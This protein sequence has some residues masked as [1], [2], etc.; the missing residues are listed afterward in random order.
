MDAGFVGKGVGTDN[1]LVGLD[2]H[3]RIA[4]DHVA[5]AV[6]LLRLHIGAQAVELRPGIESHDELLQRRV[7]R[8]FADAVNGHLHL[9]GSGRDGR[10]RVGSGQ[11][12][13][14]VCVRAEDYVPPA[15]RAFDQLP[16]QRLI[17]LRLRVA[18]GVGDVERGRAG[19]NC[20]LQHLLEVLDVATPGILRTE[21]DI[22]AQADRVLHHLAHRLQYLVARHAQLVLQMNV[23]GRNEGVDA[24]PHGRFGGG[25]RP[26]D[27]H[28]VGAGQPGDH[29][30]R[31]CA[32]V[33]ADTD[34][35]PD[36]LRHPVD[37]LPVAGAGNG[38]ARLED[39]DAQ[40]GQLASQ[41]Q[42]FVVVQCCTRTLFTIPQ[43]GVENQDGVPAG[44]LAGVRRHVL[45]GELAAINRRVAFRLLRAGCCIH[46]STPMNGPDGPLSLRLH[47]RFPGR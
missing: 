2:D 16:E 24:R 6:D 5:R 1:R 18:D 40:A 11:T 42:L 20:H 19:L 10:Q 28:A 31:Q 37:R 39:V 22:A 4:A 25:K 44:H 21:L 23:A 46:C 8:T 38:K 17:L 34:F 32:A 45:N 27:V 9:P 35:A 12:Q 13:V 36:G 14:V 30:R 29:R 15:R 3:A 47:A 43:G 26:F 41:L 7:P 33:L